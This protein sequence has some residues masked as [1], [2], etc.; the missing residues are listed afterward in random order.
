MKGHVLFCIVVISV[1]GAQAVAD[2]THSRPHMNSSDEYVFDPNLFRG[3]KFSQASLIRL[4]KPDSI[5]PGKYKLET[6]VNGHF[7]GQ[8]DITFI[9]QD[10]GT[11][12]PCL[13]TETMRLIGLKTSGVDTKREISIGKCQLI[14]QAA[15]GSTYTLDLGRLRVDFSIPQALLNKTPRGFVAPD[16][17][18][19]GSSLGFVNYIANYYHV[20][21]SEDNISDKDSAWLSLN[22]GMNFGR[23]QYRQLS[24]LTWDKVRGGQWNNVRTF[25][26][27]PVPALRSQLLM[28]ELITNGRFFSGLNYDGVSLATDDRMLP[29]SMR[30]YAP[31]IRGVAVTN[32]KVSVRQNGSEIYQT[33]VAPGAFVINDLYPTSYSGDLDVTITEASGTVSQFTVP[34]SAVPESM[35][36]GL[37]RYT[38]EVGK[39]HDSGDDAFFSDLVWQYGISNAITANSGLRISDGY[40][41]VMLGGVYGSDFGAFGSDL[42]YSRANL[43][44]SGYTNGWMAHLTWSKTFQPTDTTVSLAGYRYS[45]EGYRDLSDVLGLRAAWKNGGTSN[46]QSKTYRQRSRFDISVSQSLAR[47]GNIFLSGATQNYRGGCNH[48]TQLQF[49]YSNTI[50]WDISMNLSIG[51]QRSGGYIGSDSKMQTITSLSFSVPLGSGSRSAGLTNTWTHSTDGD[52][53]YQ[54][55]ISG[56]IDKAM[57]TSYNLNVT[58]DQQRRQTAIGG[59]IQKRTSWN[60]LG[61]NASLGD[62]YWQTSGTAQGALV[63]HSGGFTAGPY[64]GDTF[65]LVEA[66][67]ATGAKIFSSQQVAIDNRGYALVPAV[68]PYR[69]NRI[70]LDPQG[71]EGDAELVDSE[72]QIAPVAGAGVKVVFRTRTGMPLLIRSR[73]SDGQPV[74]LGADVLNEKGEMVGMTGQGGQI[75]AR[76][77]KTKGTLTVRWGDEARE[78]CRLPYQVTDEQHGN[79]LIRLSA[80]CKY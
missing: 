31:V 1:S 70:T 22:G 64:L 12:Q 8:H 28:G 67:G 9:E 43:P 40:Q 33:T 24:N 17:L 6:Y 69:Y 59:N 52:D 47:Y 35:R 56:M 26:Q 14:W 63:V 3:G 15:R 45:T 78:H 46:W 55:S 53:Q 2:S 11:A 39:T 74:P 19:T 21:Y 48:D 20:S 37:S 18:D 51:R 54:S 72:K 29:D 13:T 44:D 30:G 57:T 16:E 10:D 36:P 38:V 75:Y 50:A 65:A 62:G 32:A 25:F 34:F 66:K 77:E 5:L 27:R 80:V 58:R 79:A 42:T 7:L 68:T 61:L 60:T 73:L 49:G 71:M 76:T 41:S 23:W 4:T